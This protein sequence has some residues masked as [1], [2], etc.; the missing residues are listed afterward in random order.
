M[1]SSSPLAVRPNL[2]DGDVPPLTHC[3]RNG[4]PYARLAGVEDEIRRARASPPGEWNLG[5]MG[6]ET[7]VHLIRFV[8]SNS[9]SDDLLG[10]LFEQLGRRA[11]RIVGDFAKGFSETDTDEIEGKVSLRVVELVLAETPARKSEYLEVLFRRVV[12]GLT[13]NEV[14]SRED[15]PRLQQFAVLPENA[16]A[17]STGTDQ[18]AAVPDDGPGPEEIVSREEVRELVRTNLA[19]V[20][21]PRHREAVVLCYLQEW[22]VTD[23]NP[24]TPTLCTHFEKADRQIRNWMKAALNEMREAIGENP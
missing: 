12:K 7:L 3:D 23:K 21:D 14:E 10:L 20:T 5:K 11:A 22:P 2:P 18:S 13:L 4:T 17:F 24:E 9:G 1:K 19:A 8:R 15:H 16:D 6:S